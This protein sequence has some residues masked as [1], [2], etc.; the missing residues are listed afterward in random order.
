MPHRCTKCG[1]LFRDGDRRI[2]S[3]C[4]ECGWNKFL[5]ESLGSKEEDEVEEV[6]G[7]DMVG[8]ESIR[9]LSP[10]SYELNIKQLLEREEIILGA[11]DEGTY[12]IHLPSLFRKRRGD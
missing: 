8:I 5:Y 1:E 10:G 12:L 7:V 3:G 6:E 2:L 11:R 9:I 4:P